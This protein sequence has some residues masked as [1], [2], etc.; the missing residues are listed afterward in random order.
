MLESILESREWTIG[1]DGTI[2]E[3]SANAYKKLKESV[4]NLP[5]K[6]TDLFLKEQL[7]TFINILKKGK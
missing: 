7:M 1:T 5:K 3:V 4:S 6:E 2:I